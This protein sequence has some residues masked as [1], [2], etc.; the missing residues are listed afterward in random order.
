MNDNESETS[1]IERDERRN[2]EGDKKESGDFQQFD[3][4][5]IGQQPDDMS[6][7]DLAVEVSY[8]TTKKV[9]VRLQKIDYVSCMA[10]DMDFDETTVKYHVE[11]LQYL[12]LVEIYAERSDRTLYKITDK[13]RDILEKVN[14]LQ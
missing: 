10:E 4:D 9:L 8:K 1:E 14:I 6:Y 2:D 12:E 11:K 3:P 13:G 7:D 5:T